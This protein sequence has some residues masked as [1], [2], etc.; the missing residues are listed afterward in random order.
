MKRTYMLLLA[1]T[2]LFSVNARAQDSNQNDNQD[3]TLQ[4]QEVYGEGNV[5]VM[6]IDNQMTN[7]AP[8]DADSNAMPSSSNTGGMMVE[9]DISEEEVMTNE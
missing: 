2:V 8:N 7:S 6:P 1:A 9:E 5:E 4:V 3:G